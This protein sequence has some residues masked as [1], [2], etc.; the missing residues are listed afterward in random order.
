MS[1]DPRRSSREM[2]VGLL[3]LAALGIAG[4]GI[5]LIGDRRNLFE[6]KNEYTIDFQTV[7]GLKEGNP[8]QLDGVA[9]GEVSKVDLPENPS[10]QHIR[11]HIQVGRTYENRIRAGQ[12]LAGAGGRPLPKTQARIKTLGLLGDKYIE[13]SSGAPQYPKVPS[14]GAIPAAVP[15]NVDAL[16]ASGEDV[17][18]NVVEI[19]HS[20]SA[21]LGRMERGEGLLGQLTSNSPE[22]NRL[23]QSMLGT[24]ESAE[25]IATKIDQG[26]GPLPRLLN[27]RAM[28]DRLASSLERFEKILASAESGPGLLPG[29][30]NDPTAKQS[31]QET[32]ASLRASA[33]DLQGL[34][35]GLEGSEALLP[36]LLKDEAYGK[37]ITDEIRTLIEGLN[38]LSLRLTQGEGTAAKLI[39]DPAIYDAV[40]DVVIGIND[41]KI[42][43]WLIRN[44]QKA[45]IEKR[46]KEVR[47]REAAAPTAPPS[48]PERP[49]DEPTS[50]PPPV[51]LQPDPSTAPPPS[52]T[53][54]GSEDASRLWSGPSCPSTF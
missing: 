5:L 19:S 51:N 24:F 28:A 17:M 29:L 54:A 32:L 10:I 25:R 26:D 15:T 27:D 2:K 49:Q 37:E 43:R 31:F 34:T 46:A 40:N 38:E 3:L 42:L 16:I 30:L 13:I 35:S 1:V 50:E 47:E 23:R 53:R 39:N 20:L 18:G 4:A 12:T 11:V 9:V 44:R 21:I 45:G 41:S 8:V 52:A 6:R 33:G 14:G 36:K 7:S 22:S 48:T